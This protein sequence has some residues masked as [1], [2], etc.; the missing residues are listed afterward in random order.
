MARVL[1]IGDLHCPADRPKYLEF[2]KDLYKDWGCDTV[3][4]IGDII[5]WHSISF[6]AANPE[7][8]GPRDEYLLAKKHLKRWATAFPKA[9]VCIGNHDERPQRLARTVHIPD[10]MLK[11]YGE[12]WEAPEWDWDYSHHI[13]NV[14]YRHG[15]PGRGGG[16]IHPA[17][18]VMNKVHQ[19]VVL[20]H[21]HSRAGIKWSANLD[22]RFFAMDVGCGINDIMMQFAYGHDAV[23]KSILAAGIIFKGNHTRVN[24]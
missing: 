1:V 23:E 13:D 22:A 2:C 4:F 11:S 9:K 16:G 3:V 8:P 14:L 6:W 15:P 12:L 10:F 18:N 7:C 19:S 21:C 24:L 5:D 17:W 20:G